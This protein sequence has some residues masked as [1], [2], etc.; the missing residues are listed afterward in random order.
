M[1]YLILA[2]V[3]VSIVDIKDLKSKNKKKD[4][5]VYVTIMLLVGALGFFYYSNQ[6]RDSFS[7]VLLSLI[8]KEG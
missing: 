8:G 5:Y 6:E 1:V 3:I 4:F 2:I 7:K